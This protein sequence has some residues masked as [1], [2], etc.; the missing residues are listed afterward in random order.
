M[1]LLFLFLTVG[2]TVY[3]MEST[4]GRNP[5]EFVIPLM[6]LVLMPEACIG[7]EANADVFNFIEDHEFAYVVNSQRL[8]FPMEMKVLRFL[9][10]KCIKIENG[11]PIFIMND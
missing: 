1:A 11:F 7:Q 10:L 5:I 8:S 3:S 6:P 9:G 4:V 2:G